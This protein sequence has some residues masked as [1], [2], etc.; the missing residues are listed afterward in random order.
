M[1]DFKENVIRIA[2]VDD[3]K[4]FIDGIK[5]ILQDQV[6]LK[7]VAEAYSGAQIESVLRTNEV[8]LLFLDLNM[9]GMDGIEVLKKLK[10]RW[11]TLKIIIITQYD[12]PKLIDLIR[13]N[14]GNG[15]LIKSVSKQEILHSIHE[16]MEGKFYLSEGLNERNVSRNSTEEIHTKYSDS[17]LKRHNITKREAEIISLV[18]SSL[19]TK[20]IA[21][22][23]FISEM[24]VSTHRK[25]I[26]SKLKLKNTAELIRFAFE[27]NLI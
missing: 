19:S 1:G 27:N 9:P 24:T 15:Y 12:D 5:S 17:F 8:D 18:A 21:Q 4:I 7:I 25:K 10:S 26:K 16:V 20:E 13:E 14:K 6:H 11:P 3:H 23:L 22:K 2:I